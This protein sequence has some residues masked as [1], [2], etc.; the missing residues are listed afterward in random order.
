MRGFFT[1]VCSSDT[2]SPPDLGRAASSVFFSLGLGPGFFLTFPSTV[3]FDG[4]LVAAAFLLMAGEVCFARDGE[5]DDAGV[6]DD[7]AAGLI[8]FHHPSVWAL[9]EGQILSL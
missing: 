9:S 2:A 4:L 6:D 3:T 5:C 7:G 1:L 8:D